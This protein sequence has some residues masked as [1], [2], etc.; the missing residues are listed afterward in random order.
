MR[1][2]IAIFGSTGSI[3]NTLLKII[4]ANKNKF[5]IVLLSANEDYI[6]LAQQAKKFKVKNLILINKKKIKLLK[7]NTKDLDVNIY[8]NFDFIKSIF[9]NKIDYIMCALTGIDGLKPT[10]N[11]IKYTKK[12]AIANKE[13]IIC[14]W[15]LIRK[16]L[17]KFKTQFIP[18]D[19]EHFTIWYGIKNNNDKID[20]LFL[21]ASGGPFLNL[22]IKNFKKINLNEALKHPS[23]KMG[24]K[25]S[26]DS[27]TMMN[28]VFEVIEAK[29][30]FDISYQ[31][32]SILTHPISYVHSILKFKNGIIKIIAHDTDM[33][34]PIFNSVINEN[35]NN[36]IK[37]KEVDI[38]KLNSLNLK[39]IDKKKFKLVKILDTL[40]KKNSLYETILVSA[41]DEFVK[42]FLEGK[43]RF[44]DIQKKLLNFIN[45]SEFNKYKKIQPLNINKILQLNKY[46]RLK[47]NTKCI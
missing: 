36:V 27:A 21:T 28:K 15:N 34:I 46:V 1:K 6:S 20:K 14:G 22:P 16:E 35:D 40:P 32:I 8:N 31:K 41:N 12:I 17:K 30:I 25:I 29:N 2:K 24:K 13:S 37:T 3:G 18:V 39:N 26:I 44:S 7:E 11:S 23:W 38:S 9:K 10:I 47:I 19:S 42:L 4:S 33:K 43:I 45:K 5:E